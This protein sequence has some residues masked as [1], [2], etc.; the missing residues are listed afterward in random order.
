MENDVGGTSLLAEDVGVPSSSHVLATVDDVVVGFKR[1]KD[2]IMECLVGHEKGLKVISIVGMPGIGKTTLAM[3]LFKS[4]SLVHHFDILARGIV[5]QNF[6]KRR[7]I[8]AVLSHVKAL[9]SMDISQLD[10]ETL[11]D[12]LCKSLKKRKY[13]LLIDDVW[14][15]NVWQDLKRYLPDDKQGS[16]ILITTRNSCVASDIGSQ[17]HTLSLLN[18]DESWELF[19]KRLSQRENLSENLLNIAKKISEGCKGLPLSIVVIAGVLS[20][21]ERSEEIWNQIARSL[22]LHILADPQFSCKTILG[23]SFNNLPQYLQP[24]FLYLGVFPEDQE[25][26]VSRLKWLWMA[27]GF[28]QDTEQ[29]SSEDVAKVYIMSLLM[30]NLVIPA[31]ERSEGGVKTFHLHDLLRDFCIEKAKEG[32]HNLRVLKHINH[33]SIRLISNP[34]GSSH[35]RLSSHNIHSLLLF[36]REGNDKMY[37]IIM[38]N[39][40]MQLQVLD[41]PNLLYTSDDIS[42]L[43]GLRY[44]AIWR[45]M[46]NYST[47]I[48]SITMLQNLQTLI[49]EELLPF[50]SDVVEVPDSIWDLLKL[51]HLHVRNRA[52]FELD[53]LR[54]QNNPSFLLED[55][56]SLSKPMLSHDDLKWLRKLPKLQKL[57]CIISDTWDDCLK[58]HRLPEMDF[59]SQ[60]MSLKMELW[61]QSEEDMRRYNFHLPLSLKK[62]TLRNFILNSVDVS[63]IGKMLPFLQVLK[64]YQ[65]GPWDSK[66]VEVEEWSVNDDDFP[67]LKVLKLAGVRFNKWTTSDDS[68]PCLEK[69]WVENC[70]YLEAI[71]LQFGDIPELRLIFV[72]NCRMSVDNSAKEIER[73]QQEGQN[74]E[75]EVFIYPKKPKRTKDDGPA[76]EDSQDSEEDGQKG[77]SH[78]GVGFKEFWG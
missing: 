32:K 40:M 44:L 37:P 70:Y 72:R 77:E 45:S 13:L 5:S 68:F 21:A 16:R 53:S 62:L 54:I 27:E 74:A 36:S 33:S 57:S 14:D 71:P 25:I 50:G 20:N 60:I 69:L 23:T 65:S 52:S 24:C 26:S 11:A 35:N 76:D 29:K 31:K 59:L 28:V 10:E 17:V 48:P 4:D 56:R 3:N 6:D 49:F 39:G 51:R 47:S 42:H 2:T 64:L 46:A 34:P 9:S 58:C 7:L 8:L 73:I 30:R 15:I 38:S 19:Q 41:A 61:M 18:E 43:V 22:N 55:L 63:E 75:L 12:M 1:E 67:Q 78:S 66:E